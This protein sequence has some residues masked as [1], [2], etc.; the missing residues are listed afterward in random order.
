MVRCSR[1]MNC[2]KNSLA[3]QKNGGIIHTTNKALQKRNPEWG[4]VAHGQC[5]ITV[6]YEQRNSSFLFFIIPAFKNPLW[7]TGAILSPLTGGNQ[8]CW[9][10]WLFLS[11]WWE[12]MKEPKL[13]STKFLHILLRLSLLNPHHSWQKHFT[14][15]FPVG[16]WRF[17]PSCSFV[18]PSL[19]QE[20][21]S[22]SS[23]RMIWL[24]LTTFRFTMKNRLGA[25][26][27]LGS[28]FQRDSVP[29]KG[30]IMMRRGRGMGSMRTNEISWGKENKI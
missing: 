9:A 3:F 13:E 20:H 15:L 12:L 23:L 26:R 17:S 8:G 19:R 11:L 5:K 29:Q 2:L 14:L 28:L 16:F 7:N 6:A 1:I 22:K 21:S 18:W 27:Y 25:P 4:I 10:W 24:A 30:Q